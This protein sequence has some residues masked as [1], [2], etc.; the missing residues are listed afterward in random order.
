MDLQETLLPEEAAKVL[1]ISE[2]KLGRLRR[3]GKLHGIKVTKRLFVYRV[4]DLRDADLTLQ[5]RGP[6]PKQ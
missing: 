4:A 5:K 3:S 6:K 2:Q 1:N